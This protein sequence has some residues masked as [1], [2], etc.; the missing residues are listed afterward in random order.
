M[1]RGRFIE[2][3][4]CI[5]KTVN[6]LS[7]FESMLGF[8]WLITHLDC[9]GRTYGDPAV[10]RSFVFPRRNDIT[11]E[12]MTSFIQEWHDAGLIIWYE[13]NGD[14][15]IYFPKF[16][17]Y[18]IGL[19]P[20]REAKSVIPTHEQVGSKSGE[21]QEQI[22]VKVKVK[23]KG[24]R[25]NDKGKVEVKD[26]KHDNNP[27]NQLL[28]TFSEHTKLDYGAN[29]EKIALELIQKGVIQSDIVNAINFLNSKPEYKCVSFKSIRAPALIEMERRKNSKKKVDPEDH[30]RYLK[31]E[32]GDFGNH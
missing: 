31:G 19:N 5:D 26:E 27:Q 30:R 23:S 32:Y 3:K 10:V 28:K 25:V 14:K 4:I 24:L 9:D 17:I 21:D 13:V 12:Q 1:A 6:E 20:K 11:I 29:A 7:C 22:P 16:K 2:K 8:T 15:Y 18:Q